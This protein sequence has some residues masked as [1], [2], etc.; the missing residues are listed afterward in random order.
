[1]RANVSIT[2]TRHTGRSSKEE[3][4]EQVNFDD[5]QC[6]FIEVSRAAIAL[7]E[8]FVKNTRFGRR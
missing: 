3:M 6:T 5:E 2:F 1:M 8:L 7:L 4:S